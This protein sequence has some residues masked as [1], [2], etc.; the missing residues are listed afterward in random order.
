MSSTGN[1]NTEMSLWPLSPSSPPGGP[2]SRQRLLVVDIKVMSLSV[3]SWELQKTSQGL[4]ARSP[5]STTSFFFLFGI[6]DTKH[7]LD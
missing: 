6:L 7:H 2:L 1:W 5:S 4:K 3:S